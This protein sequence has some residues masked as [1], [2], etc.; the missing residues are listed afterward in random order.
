MHTDQQFRLLLKI[1]VCRKSPSP[2]TLSRQE[3]EGE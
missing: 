1:Q 2:L 3:G